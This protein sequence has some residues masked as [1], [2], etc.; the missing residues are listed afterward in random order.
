MGLAT[1]RHLSVY[2]KTTETC[3]LN[4]SHCFTSGINGAKIYFDPVRTA[5]WVN[6]LDRDTI[7]YEFHGGEP[8]LA[9]VESMRKF[10][11][12]TKGEGVDYGMT[13]NL[14]YKLTDEKLEF[15]DD[16]LNKRIGT[17]WDPTIRFTNDRQRKLWEDNVKLLVERGYTIKCFVSL[18]K[19]VVNMEPRDIVSYM[20]SLGVRELDF[21]RITMDGNAKGKMWPSNI[22]LDEWFMRYHNQIESR[23]SIFH[24]IMENIYAKFEDN[25]PSRGTW[26]RDC[27]QKL[28]TINADGS[29]AG[30]PNTAPHKAYGHIDTPAKEVM[31]STGRCDI[32]IKEL[33]RNPACYSCPVFDVC[34]SDCHQ[35]EWEGEICP[36]PK[37]LMQH[38]KDIN[39][40]HI[41]RI[42]A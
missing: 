24:V 13:T 34:G 33:N 21:E 28:L 18:S 39:N 6:Q 38:L 40:V 4:C 30:C 36:S 16:V 31:K 42:G 29:I 26:C 10:V 17:S 23:D 27:E 2:V 5:N 1:Q 9:S 14:V 37:S 8:M 22:E 19:D 15:F 41:L 35:L 7:F 3:N 20:E 12:L 11:E 32:I 25:N